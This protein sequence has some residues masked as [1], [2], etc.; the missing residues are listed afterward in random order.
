MPLGSNGGSKRGRS[1]FGR[2]SLQSG[3]RAV[4]GTSWVGVLGGGPILGGSWV[5]KNSTVSNPD[6]VVT[7][8]FLLLASIHFQ[9]PI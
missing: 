5:V 9:S 3:F 4:V 8:S 2:G 6:K 1:L 7:A